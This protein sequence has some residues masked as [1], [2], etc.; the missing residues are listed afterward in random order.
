M[1]TAKNDNFVVIIETGTYTADQMSTEIQNK[2]NSVVTD[3]LVGSSS[4]FTP[5]QA[6][7]YKSA[8]GY[9]EFVT[10]FHVVNRRLWIGNRSSEFMLTNTDTAQYEEQSHL[11]LC[12]NRDIQPGFKRWGLPGNLGFTRCNVTSTQQTD[13]N[14]TRFFY[15]DVVSGDN[16]QW[17]LANTVLTGASAYFVQAPL[18]IDLRPPA[19]CYMDIKL[20]NSLMRQHHIIS[21]NLLKKLIKQMEK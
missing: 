12:E 15:G 16:G 4:T 18:Q 14:Q 17:L 19:Y 13:E 8:G 1:L 9:Q 3:Y 10:A 7:A 20:L 11:C 2:L 5:A 6:D 21:V